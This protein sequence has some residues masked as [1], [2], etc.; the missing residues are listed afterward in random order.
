M[1]V[2]HICMVAYIDG[3]GYQDNLL[4][5]YM[6][7]AGHDVVVVTSKNHFPS[8]LKETEIRKIQEKG[9]DYYYGNVHVYRILTNITTAN[10]TFFCSGLNDILKKEKPD[11]IFH[12]GVN[13]SSMLLCW[14][15]VLLHPSTNFFID[16]HSDKIN[17]SPK[18]LWNFF[19]I[20]GL[21]RLCTKLVQ[22]K[23][24]KFYGVTPGRCDYFKEVYGA[25]PSKIDLMPIGCDTNSIDIIDSDKEKLRE[26]YN[27]PIDAFI[28]VSGGKMGIDKGTI[29]L[30]ES[31]KSLK[32]LKSNVILVLFGRFTDRETEELA[33]C[34]SG[35]YIY[36]WC[37]RIQ[38][39]ELL[40]LS[41][42]ACWPI[43]HTTLIEDAVGAAIPLVVRHTSN[44]SHI[45]EQNG[46]Y[47]ESGG[48]D[49]IFNAIQKIIVNYDAYK[50]DTVRMRNKYSYK[51][52]VSQFEI[53]C[54][55]I[56]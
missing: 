5:D 53:D 43:H 12:H 55:S 45:I 30:I 20:G 39:L 7:Q 21:M 23:V 8:F 56:R 10:Y 44:T 38:T 33:K 19:V 50:K 51:A 31:Y 4:P 18:K 25:C 13:S 47:V 36:G 22:S 37:D 29:S 42:I 35:V 46:E 48:K 27:I 28:L 1:K 26:K 17:E 2:V 15:Y 11:A 14:Y 52:L 16:N 24:T 49:E 6:T 34:T 41:D 54:K 3:W 32:E 40:K 9:Y